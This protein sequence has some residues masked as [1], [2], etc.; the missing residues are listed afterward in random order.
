[1]PSYPFFSGV[2]F[3]KEIK[4]GAKALTV[5]RQV[6]AHSL[7]NFIDRVQVLPPE[8][9]RLFL[10]ETPR[11]NLGVAENIA[12][13]LKLDSYGRWSK[14]LEI[15]EILEVE[16]DHATHFNTRLMSRATLISDYGIIALCEGLITVA[17]AVVIHPLA[18]T[19]L[20]TNN[21]IDALREGLITLEQV[22]SMDSCNLCYLLKGNGIAALRE[23]LITPDQAAAMY[24][25]DL[26]IF[27]EALAKNFH[28]EAETRLSP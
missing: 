21:G 24:W 17:Q 26:R 4:F 2:L 11:Y 3:N 9:Q 19:Y 25:D 5:W 28:K 27:L 22:T 16:Q 1:M 23:G 15:L 7:A 6:G 18:L 8:I 10:E 12:Q 14:I 20:M 13:I